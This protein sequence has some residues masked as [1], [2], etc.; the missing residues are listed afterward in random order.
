MIIGTPAY[1][2][3]EQAQGQKLDHRTDIYSLG[4]VLYEMATGQLPF[5]ADDI[6]A[7]LLQ[8][9][10][11]PPPPPRL[12][13]P[14]LP[15]ALEKVILNALE[16][17]PSRRYQTSAALAT[18]LLAVVTGDVTSPEPT[19]PHPP[20]PGGLLP[21]EEVDQAGAPAAEKPHKPALRVLLADDHT[22]LRKSLAGFL[23][24]H[25]EFAVVGEAGDGES[26]LTQV[27]ALLPDV[28]LLDLNMPGKGGL[29]I[30]PQVRAKAPNVRVLVLT[31][32][33]E[34]SYIV[35]ALR[36]GAHGYLLK[37]AEE[38]E[39]IDAIRKVMLDQLV[40]GRGVA[41]KIVSGL[42]TGHSE[43][44]TKLNDTERQVLLY[45]AGGYENDAIAKH[46]QISMPTVIET[47]A[48]AMDKLGAKD[49][50]AAAL[51]ALRQGDILLEELHAL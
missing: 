20:V 35:R 29:D 43:N 42:L 32:R 19:R 41:E 12:L 9:V 4:V 11:Q 14:N 39:L 10:K 48:R 5:D 23:E 34:D 30:L 40:L 36:A 16:K 51:Q 24:S 1:L 15:E 13:V 31:G 38:A 17:N 49:R 33:D 7:L 2:S 26:A 45:V 37:S 21:T 50:Y 46:L 8:Q 27:L 44:Q 25:D 6:S 28:L 22:I 18:A 3:P 47:L